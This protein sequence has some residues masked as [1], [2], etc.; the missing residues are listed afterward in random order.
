[1]TTTAR[2]LSLV[3][4]LLVPACVHVTTDPIEVKPITVNVNIKN[5]DQQLDQF[6]AFENKDQP[7]TTQQLTTRP[8]TVTQ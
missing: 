3:P 7:A 2:L 4:L 1:M 5:V 8:A 6:F